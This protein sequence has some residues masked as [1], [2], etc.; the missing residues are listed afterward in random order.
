MSAIMFTLRK[1]WQN[2]RHDRTSLVLNVVVLTLT[3][4]T[5]IVVGV[6]MAN[7]D[8]LTRSIE[9]QYQIT[10]YLADD[11]T[12]ER[13]GEVAAGLRHVQGVSEVT[14]L[15]PGSFRSRFIETA[16]TD[17]DGIADVTTD[18]FPSVLE[19]G[20]EADYREKMDLAA[21]AGKVSRIDAVESVETHE[22]W[23][24][25]L[26]GF[27]SVLGLVAAVFGICVLLCAVFIVANTIKLAFI[28][29]QRVVEVMRLF[30]ATRN[31][32]EAPVLLEGALH[33]IAGSLAALVLA[34]A[35]V[36]AVDARISAILGGGEAWS[37]VFVPASWVVLFVAM[38]AVVGVVGAHLASARALRV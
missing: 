29:R 34:W 38:C 10:V 13:V 18:V 36:A 32:I 26:K 28:K 11:V 35:L 31:L 15:D 17:I 4:F 37:V 9:D 8:R 33:G 12:P 23:L 21:F 22:G 7:V 3:F 24:Q 30:G 20:L 5:V 16:G 19:V 25:Q 2:V 27:A 14:H 6:G 1:L